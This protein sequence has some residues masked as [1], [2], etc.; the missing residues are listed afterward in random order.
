MRGEEAHF[1]LST[2]AG[3]ALELR[4]QEELEKLLRNI[5][6]PNTDPQAKRVLQVQLT[7]KP[8]KSRTGAEVAIS[9][10]SKLAPHRALEI[11]T[12]IGLSRQA[13]H[14]VITEHQQLGL[15]LAERRVADEAQPTERK[16]S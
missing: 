4:F 2:I 13:G 5:D 11:D 15:E 1:T 12:F 16:P 6:D 14:Y 10:T 8:G 3:G 9:V 7:L